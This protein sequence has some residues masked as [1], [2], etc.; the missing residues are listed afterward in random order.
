MYSV[1]LNLNNWKKLIKGKKMLL[2]TESHGS[3]SLDI[4]VTLVL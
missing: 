1:D 3:E 2:Y 4:T